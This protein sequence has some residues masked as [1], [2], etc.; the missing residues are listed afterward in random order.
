MIIMLSKVTTRDL[1]YTVLLN[2]YYGTIFIKELNVGGG[3]SGEA[4]PDVMSRV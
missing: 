1:T 4:K 3:K 2:C